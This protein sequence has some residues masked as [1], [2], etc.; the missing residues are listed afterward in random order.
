MSGIKRTKILAVHHENGNIKSVAVVADRRELAADLRPQL[1]ELVT[2][3]EVL[4]SELE[5]FRRNPCDII[6]NFFV[7]RTHARLMPRLD[8]QNAGD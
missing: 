6:Q 4:D 8:A 1:G 3:V 2:E 5:R 7:D